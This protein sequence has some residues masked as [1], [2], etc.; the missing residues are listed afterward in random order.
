MPNYDEDTEWN[1]I[2]RAKGII[3]EKPAKEAKALVYARVPQDDRHINN[4]KPD[5]DEQ[6]YEDDDELL[7]E[8]QDAMDDDQF[9]AEYRNKRLQEMKRQSKF[10]T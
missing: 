10:M 2:L 3:P 1:D 5:A 7:A 4:K 6:P 8:L 9:M